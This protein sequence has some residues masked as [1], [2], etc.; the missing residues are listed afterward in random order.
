MRRTYINAALVVCLCAPLFATAQDAANDQATAQRATQLAGQVERTIKTR[1]RAWRLK[2]TH[3]EGR[4]SSQ[5]W[6]A[7]PRDLELKIYVYDS[8][9]EAS[10]ML[11]QHGVF[12]VAL[13]HDLKDF[14]DEARVVTHPYFTWIGVRRGNM[15]AEVHGPGKEVE[16]SKR[17]AQY[18][19]ETLSRK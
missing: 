11:D 3:S 4:V 12:A 16:L 15:L 1:E 10:K 17:F 9:E 5:R 13:S 6:M 7:G 18:A 8:P 19:L 2:E 14:G